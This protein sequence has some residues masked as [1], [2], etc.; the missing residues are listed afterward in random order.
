MTPEEIKAELAACLKL[1]NEL[2]DKTDEL[3]AR[4]KAIL[5]A[6]D[7]INMRPVVV[8][9][10]GTIYRLERRDDLVP[11]NE[12]LRVARKHGGFYAGYRLVKMGK[13]L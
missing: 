5:D 10:E 2:S 13:P 7:Q 11:M 6:C 9:I 12:Q 3:T 8:E 1:Q 4:Y